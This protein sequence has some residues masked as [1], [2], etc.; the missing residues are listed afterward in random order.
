MLE[1]QS[2]YLFFKSINSKLSDFQAI[3]ASALQLNYYNNI[4]V[5]T[6][7]IKKKIFKKYAFKILKQVHFKINILKILKTI[8][9]F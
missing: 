3:I 2:F 8:K 7:K 9:S 1:I 5:T 6:A 4:I